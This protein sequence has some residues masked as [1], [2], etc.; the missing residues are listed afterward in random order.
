MRIPPYE[1][2]H[3][4]ALIGTLTSTLVLII[5]VYCVWYPYLETSQFISA[6][7]VPFAFTDTGP[8]TCQPLQPSPCSPILPPGTDV[9]GYFN[10]S[11]RSTT[12][13]T[14]TFTSVT[15][16][17]TTSTPPTTSTTTASASTP[18]S[19]V[20]TTTT[21]I[22]TSNTISTATQSAASSST[23]SKISPTAKRRKR[24]VST[25]LPDWLSSVSPPSEPVCN[26]FPCILVTVIFKTT[27]GVA[28]ESYGVLYTDYDQMT[29]YPKVC[30]AGSD[31][32]DF[33]FI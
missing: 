25:T 22:T 8:T 16:D 32:C 13:V 3:A 4:I 27:Y 7:C 30:C 18:S 12:T 5:T 24:D 19:T 6:Q 23:L 29:T 31:T 1:K 2:S 28:Y 21:S 15:T 14:E 10:V 26:S 33:R 17:S 9:T 11:T 20:S